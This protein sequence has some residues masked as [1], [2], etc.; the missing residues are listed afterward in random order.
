MLPQQT[1][2]E[3]NCMY[4]ITLCHSLEHFSSPGIYS[5]DNS[6][7]THSEGVRTSAIVPNLLVTAK[8]MTIFKQIFSS[9]LVKAWIE[10][11][12]STRRKTNGL[13]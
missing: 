12:H 9:A 4:I 11:V 6:A 5:S 7:E 2:N 8:I 1:A 13:L 3:Q 10:V